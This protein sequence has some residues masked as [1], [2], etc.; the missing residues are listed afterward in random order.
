MQ[1]IFYINWFSS[2]IQSIEASD[3]E[4]IYPWPENYIILQRDPVNVVAI[5]S[6]VNKVYLDVQI[7]IH[8]SLFI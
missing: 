5:L 8:L 1:L 3:I 7:Y 4:T 6:L 2:Y